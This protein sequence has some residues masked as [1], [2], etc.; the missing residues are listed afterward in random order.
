MKK[1]HK[2]I[3]AAVAGVILTV[4][5]LIF[6]TPEFFRYQSR[7]NA[8]NQVTLNEIKIRQQAQ[9]I[10]VEKQKAEIREQEAIGI[11]KAQAI[12]N[13][14]LTDRFLQLEAIKAQEQMAGSPNHT[15]IY[16]PVGQNGIPI[17]KNIDIKE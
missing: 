1:E 10:E 5:M 7:M 6:A 8:N 12:I 11:A 15:Q 3:A 4:C 16:I 2:V 9:L 14:T 13:A 17:V